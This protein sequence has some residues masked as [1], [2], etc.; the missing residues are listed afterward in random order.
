[1]KW[2]LILVCSAC[3][4]G[5]TSVGQEKMEADRP[6][7]TQTAA[8]TAK[9]FLQFE[10][11]FQKEQQNGTNSS[12]LHPNTVIKY[13]LTKQLELRMDLT[14]ETEKFVS[15]NDYH[16]GLKPFEIG[17][18]AHLAEEKGFLPNTSFLGE[19]GIPMLASKDHRADHVFP[20]LR[21]LFENSI[22]K[23]ITMHYNIGAE[24]DGDNS[25][26]DWVYTIAPQFEL[27]EKVSVFIEEYG[28]FHQAEKPEHYMDG[29]FDYNISKNVKFDLYAGVGLSSEASDYFIASGISFR[30]GK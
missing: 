28:L 8:T 7:E 13:G 10:V 14:V 17:F 18:K 2:N 4:F 30:V 16:Y 15:K 25:R 5:F 11:G 29:G 6:G 21:F 20:T 1:M 23:K 3:V 19:V 24:W 26:P 22:S 27:S 12:F 9:G